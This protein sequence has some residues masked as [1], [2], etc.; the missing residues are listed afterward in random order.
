MEVIQ[1][2]E[3]EQARK[4]QPSHYEI[5]ATVDAF[6]KSSVEKKLREAFGS[7]VEIFSIEKL[8]TA[9]S[10]AERLNGAAS[11]V[12]DAAGIVEELQGEIQEWLDSVPDNLRDS[13]KASDL[14]HTIDNLE[15]L[16]NELQAVDFSTVE[17]PGMM[18]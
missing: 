16:M 5:T 7:D 8:Q 1:D 17:F 12:E 11:M 4:R 13:Q 10:R 14:Q 2:Q 18:G 6:K 9:E 15:S 3:Q